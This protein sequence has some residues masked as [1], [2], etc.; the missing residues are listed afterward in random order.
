MVSYTYIFVWDKTKM[1]SEVY[2]F[3]VIQWYLNIVMRSIIKYK[4]LKWTEWKS[5]NVEAKYFP[6]GM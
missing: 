2:C 6:F 1:P 4:M 5:D 3:S